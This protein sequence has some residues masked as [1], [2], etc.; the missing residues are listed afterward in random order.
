MKKQIRYEAKGIVWG[1]CWGGGQCGYGSK[2][3]K[4]DTQKQL[5][6][7]INK[8]IEDRS[9]DAGMGFESLE[10]AV[11]EVI[12]IETITVDDKEYTHKDYEIISYGKIQDDI[13]EHCIEHLLY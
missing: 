3:V 7:K 6:K 10:G 2:T 4:A 5:D 9:L 1:N 8:G 11:M 12:K 13:L